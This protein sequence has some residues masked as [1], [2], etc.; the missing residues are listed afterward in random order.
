MNSAHTNQRSRQSTPN[1]P[2]AIPNGGDGRKGVLTAWAFVAIAALALAGCATEIQQTPANVSAAGGALSTSQAR[3]LV[4][5]Y[6]HESF[7]D[8]YSVMDLQI[9]APVLCSYPAMNRAAEWEINFSCNAKNSFGAYI[10]KRRY[11]IFVVNGGLDWSHIHT[12]ESLVAA[13]ESI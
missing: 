2:H 1:S 12:V 8:P 13:Q 11:V 4:Q 5:Q 3:A 9:G 6:I 10:G 7:K